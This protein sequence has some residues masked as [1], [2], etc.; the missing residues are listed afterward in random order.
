MSYFYAVIFAFFYFL[1]AINAF[2]R[3]HPQAVPIAIVNVFLGWTL[4]GWVI[5]LAWSYG[6]SAK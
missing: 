4:I 3:K 1:P 5:A 2:Y 6:R